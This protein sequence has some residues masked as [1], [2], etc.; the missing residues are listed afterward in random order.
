METLRVLCPAKVNLHLRVLGR[1]ADMY[2]ELIT[3]MQPV[4]PVDELLLTI[5]GRG[6]RMAC[7]DPSLPAGEGNLAWRAAELFQ[8]ETGDRFGLTIH[9][10]KRIPVGAGLGGGSSDAAGVLR[11][12]NRMRG[13]T[14]SPE[15]LRD[16]ATR[17]GAD[18]PFFLLESAAWAQGIGERLT[19][20]RV[21]PP[22]WFVLV[23]PGWSVS[24][25]WVYEN[26][27]WGLTR[28]AKETN[29]PQLIERF[30]DVVAFLHN[31]LESVTARY[32]PWI[33]RAKARLRDLGAAGALMSGSGPT[34][35]GI[36]PDEASA[37]RAREGFVAD[38]GETIWCSRAQA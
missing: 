12:L 38:G 29:I 5:E 22:V 24:T 36:F 34:V 16:W 23:F 31:D 33:P 37:R 14:V 35:F 3:L 10:V 2:H 11:G 18:V 6:L 19:P 7:D 8:Q 21:M 15:V 27:D 9:L 32:H 26:L 28:P 4:N 1:R 20:A 17:L 30:E 13:G 25:R